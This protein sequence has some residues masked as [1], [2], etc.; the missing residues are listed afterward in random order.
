M[1]ANVRTCRVDDYCR[2]FTSLSYRFLAEIPSFEA[3][4]F[5]MGGGQYIY[6]PK[7]VY[8]NSDGLLE[9]IDILDDMNR[10]TCF[11]NRKQLTGEGPWFC[12]FPNQ[13]QHERRTSGD[14]WRA[15]IIR[16]FSSTHNGKSYC[17]PSI[18]LMSESK[19]QNLSLRLSP[20]V[21]IECFHVGDEVK[22]D[23]ELITLPLRANDY[24]GPNEA[25][26]SHLISQMP[27]ISWK[28]IHRELTL[29]NL[30]V[31]IISGGVLK[32]N[33]PL[34]IAVDDTAKELQFTI[35]RGAGAIPMR[36][37]NVSSSYCDL[38][39]NDE[40]F[41]EEVHGNDFW[42]TDYDPKTQSF[43]HSFNVPFD[44]KNSL[45]FTLK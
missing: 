43:S 28:T 37:D 26:R 22:F 18:S 15:L 12:G 1:S 3:S 40:R 11:L 20:S 4:F 10:S 33:Y 42:Q 24:Y 13:G 9:D 8:G 39:C 29:N 7:V 35:I 45:H 38:Y 32:N 14:G 2:T 44:G 21:D 19:G 41:N 5:T 23:V 30:D 31:T 16:R 36:F 6:T 25:F 27:C 17:N 34:I